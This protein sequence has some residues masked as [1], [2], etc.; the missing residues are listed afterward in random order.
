MWLE[1]LS[2]KSA[3]SPGDDEIVSNDEALGSLLGVIRKLE[4][5]DAAAASLLDEVSALGGKLP[6][7]LRSGDD[8][9]D[10]ADPQQLG[11]ILEDVKELLVNRLLVTEGCD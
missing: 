2:L 11:D 9:Y 7:E 10:P 1:K 6:A 5:D 3:P 4:V 8:G